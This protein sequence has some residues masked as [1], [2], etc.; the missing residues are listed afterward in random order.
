[1]KTVISAVMVAVAMS[2]GITVA[3]AATETRAQVV[4]QLDQAET[5]GL[6][7]E[8]ELG[9]PVQ[10]APG[11]EETHAKVQAQ[12]QAAFKDGEVNEFGM[13]NPPHMAV[14]TKTRSQVELA[15][16]QYEATHQNQFIEH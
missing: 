3:Q 10:R 5:Q 15:L 8:G 13:N 4:Q 7:S 6:I 16:Q 12:L 14:S 11:P 9:Y 1:M 2:A